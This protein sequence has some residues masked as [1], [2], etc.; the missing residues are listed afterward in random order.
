MV[1]GLLVAAASMG[2]WIYALFFYDPGLMIDQLADRT[3]PRKAEQICATARKQIATLPTAD[4]TKDPV[5]RAD[6]VD[7]ANDYLRDM[8]G[9]LSPLVPEGQGRITTGIH[10]WIADWNTY[11]ADRQEYADALRK[12]PSTRFS[13]TRKGNR[14]IS[15]AI[16]AFAQVNRMESCA[17]PG[18]VG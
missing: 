1:L 15:L 12:D 18:D 11:I 17:V 13:E 7:R 5:D 10:E 2:V 4:Q 6:T 8:T 14:Q 9:A 3:F 16:N